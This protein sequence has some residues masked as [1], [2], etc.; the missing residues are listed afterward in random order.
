MKKEWFIQHQAKNGIMVL[1]HRKT[2][3]KVWVLGN[4]EFE[5]YG[6]ALSFIEAE[7]MA[8]EAWET[9]RDASERIGVR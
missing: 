4:R 3:R 6:A 2:R 5:S 1:V 7:R 9:A 8:Q